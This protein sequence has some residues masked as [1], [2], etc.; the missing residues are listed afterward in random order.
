MKKSILF[1]IVGI[2]V[3]VG[4]VVLLLKYNQPYNEKE[5]ITA[6]ITHIN[7]TKQDYEYRD[8][9]KEKYSTRHY[10]SYDVYYEF[11]YNGEKYKGSTEY[12]N[13]FWKKNTKIKI[14]YDKELNESAI[15][16]H[17]YILYYLIII[18]MLYILVGLTAY[19]KDYDVSNLFKTPRAPLV[20]HFVL[21]VLSFIAYWGVYINL[22]SANLG[23]SGVMFLFMVVHILILIGCLTDVKN[24]FQEQEEIDLDE[25]IEID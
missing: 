1:M 7:K 17:P 19:K 25:E 3:F 6:T 24:L 15:Y 13:I 2:I 18:G 21:P 22:K 10:Y 11:K 12:Y 8:S 16:V 5:K 9:P 23:S 4:G 20:I 14:Y